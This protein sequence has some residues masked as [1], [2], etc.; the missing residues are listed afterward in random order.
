MK[1]DNLL[2]AI[3]LL[4]D[5]HFEYDKK[6]TSTVSYTAPSKR[7]LYVLIAAIIMS[8]ALGVV[9]M[10]ASPEFRELVFSFFHISQ[11][12]EIPENT[13]DTELSVDD[14]FVE[15]KI[16]I[17]DLIEGKYVHTPVA[18]QAEHGVFLA[19]TDEIEAKQGSRYDAYYENNG[20]FIKLEEHRFSQDYILHGTAFHLEF[21][22]AQHNGTA[23]ITWV[24]A[25]ENFRMSG[26]A[27]DPSAVLFQ[28][29]FTAVRLPGIRSSSA[30]YHCPSSPS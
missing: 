14:M 27:G 24:E 8:L 2:D 17:G 16:T 9:A 1:A 23:I 18:T 6:Q 25:N 12:Q 20:E 29:V 13:L 11:K 22:W 19:C 7:G 26:F 28:F 5:R 30:G 21:D 15:Q 3:G 4:E 10:A